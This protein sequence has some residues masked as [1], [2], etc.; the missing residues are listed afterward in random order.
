V[1]TQLADIETAFDQ[2]RNR[3]ASQLAT[4][5]AGRELDDRLNVYGA[6]S[7]GLGQFHGM[8]TDALG[9]D[10][11]Q[12]DELRGERGYQGDLEEQAFQRAL[13]Q[14]LTETDLQTQAFD[15][16]QRQA[17]SLSNQGYAVDPTG[18]MNYQ[19]GQL[20][21]SAMA[22][23]EGMMLW[24][25]EEARRRAAQRPTT[26]ASSGTQVGQYGPGASGAVG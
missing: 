25:Q 16:N 26:T 23:N 21:D 24:L 15:L 2:E 14:L 22:G 19:A 1:N 12:R 18:Q 10:R 9:E 11:R 20:N 7:S 4:D 13:A 8:D 6:T 3:T 5:A 17:N